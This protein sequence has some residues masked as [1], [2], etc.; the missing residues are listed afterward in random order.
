MMKTRGEQVDTMVSQVSLLGFTFHYM[1]VC[2]C[3]RGGLGV[4]WAGG[5]VVVQ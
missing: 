1:A 2:L 5:A 3:V 4:G